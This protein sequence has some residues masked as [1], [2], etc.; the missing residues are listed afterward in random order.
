MKNANDMSSWLKV[1]IEKVN[2][3]GLIQLDVVRKILSVLPIKKYECIII[4][5][6]QIVLFTTTP[7][8]ILIKSML[9]RCTYTS[10]IKMS[11]L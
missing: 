4:V 10:M 3:L 8:K 9:M 2:V 1:L 11:L 7:T 5:L 6:H